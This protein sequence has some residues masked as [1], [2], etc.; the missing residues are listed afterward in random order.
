MSYVDAACKLGVLNPSTSFGVDSMG[1]KGGLL[2]FGWTK[3]VVRLVFSSSN[4]V[5]CS[6]LESN[7]ICRYFVYVYGEPKVED[8]K[9]VWDTLAM[10]ISAYPHC[11]LIGDFNQLSSLEDKLGGSSVIRGGERFNDWLIDTGIIEVPFSGPRFIWSNKREGR[12]LIMERLDRAYVSQSWFDEF[13]N[14]RVFNE[15]IVCSDHA[16]ILYNSDCV[17]RSS[18]RP[19]QIESWCLQFPEIKELVHSSWNSR[20]L[21]SPMFRLSNSLKKLRTIM[22][23]WYLNNKKMWGINWRGTTKSL[24]TLANGVVSIEQGVEYVEKINEWL[25]RGALE[26]EY[27]RQRMKKNWIKFGDCPTPMLYRRVKQRQVR[28]EILCLKDKNDNWVE[29][30][31]RVE[32]LVVSSLKEVFNPSIQDSHLEDVDLVLRQLDLPQIKE[33]DKAMLSSNFSYEEIRKAMFDIKCCKSPGPDGF[34][35]EFFQKYW[36]LVGP[37]VCESVLN[38]FEKGYVLKEWNQS[39]LVMIPKIATP[40]LAGHF[41]PIS[42]C[43][44]IYK[45]ISKCMVNRM[46][47]CLPMLITDFQHAFIPGRYIEDNVLLSHELIHMVN[48]RKSSDAVVIKL[49]MSKAY[50]RVNWNFL[51]KV[52]LAYGFPPQWVQLVSQCISTVSYKAIVNGRMSETFRPKCGLRQGDPLSPYLFLFCMDILSRMLQMAE[53]IKQIQGL[54]VSRRAPSISHLFFADD[55]LLFFKADSTNCKNIA[56]ILGE[57]GRI[58]GQQLNL[59]KSFAKFSPHLRKEKVEEMKSLLSMPVVNNVGNHLGVPVDLSGSKSVFF[60]SLLN[61]ISNKIISWSHLHISQAAKLVLI[62][63]ILMSLA[64]H[65]MRS[66]KIPSATVHK[67]DSLIAK[68]WWA[69]N[70]ERGIHWVRREIV[71]RPKRLGGLGIRSAE[72]V[73][74]TPLFKQA[75]RIHNNPNLLISRVVN[76]RQGC[77]VCSNLSKIGLAQ[78]SSWGKRSLFQAV[79]KFEK[80]LAWKIGEGSKVKAVSMPWVE[81]RVPEVKDSQQ[82]FQARLWKV[83]DF[84]R[85]N[86]EWNHCKIRE[87]FVWK[88]ASAIVAMEQPKEGEDDY[89]Y[90]KMHPSGK[91]STKSGYSFISQQS[92]K[93]IQEVS[94]EDAIFF[95][96]IWKLDILPRWKVFLWKLMYNAVAAKE[97]LNKRGIVTITSYCGFPSEDSQ[98]IFRFCNL[99]KLVWSCSPLQ[100]CSNDNEDISLKKWIQ[101]YILLFRSKDGSDCFRID[102]FVAV[103]WSLWTTRNNRIFRN[104]NGHARLVL[105][106]VDRILDT[107]KLYKSCIPIAPKENQE[108][109]VPPGFNLVQL[110]I[111]KDKLS[112]SVLQVDGSWEKKTGKSGGGWVYKFHDDTHFQP[113]GGFYG[114]AHSAIQVE[115]E[116]C[117][118]AMQWVKQ[119]EKSEI[120][121]MID[122]SVL[123]SALR[124]AVNAD[125]RISWMIRRIKQLASTSVRFSRWTEG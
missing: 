65:V 53:N 99:A 40:I 48:T 63:S 39:L 86:H 29:G 41:R 20:S 96:L 23:R 124:N 81:G 56:D 11:V 90:W 5:L 4:L 35:A 88:D 68:F 79:K 31:K 32:D 106:N 1:S 44:T 21:G 45:C 119:Q 82:I 87:C 7:G 8:R 116:T 93:D 54:K 110:G 125:V 101:S 66:L 59:Q 103:L 34:N 9:N 42:L 30:Q 71:H 50:D 61:K 92:S 113:G 15:P 52:L 33:I 100:I 70:G 17:T 55:A 25:P 91:F 111:L 3:A 114:C 97:N 57:F 19:Y 102:C 118:R 26:F 46:K 58:S 18:N 67:I 77:L 37:M 60:Q 117:L 13:P 22:Q 49:D 47:S 105:Q 85:E 24:E 95:K 64:S 98:H 38:F 112:N 115:T 80:G 6:V 51:L 28:N 89:L 14:G 104:E 122:S 75:F 78:N 10:I 36:E 43:N 27:W 69:G 16:T 120:F 76:S 84:I 12:D 73:N 123:I 74:D 94:K 62:Q 108:G 83:K 72:L 107:S 109:E 121:I 2:V